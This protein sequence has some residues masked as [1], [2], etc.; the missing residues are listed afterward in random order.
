[1]DLAPGWEAR[2]DAYT[3]Q[4][5]EAW[6]GSGWCGSNQAFCQYCGGLLLPGER[7]SMEP[8][9]ARLDPEH[10]QAC[11]ASLQR[12]ITDSA[13]DHGALLKA[14]RDY[15]LPKLTAKHPLEAW[16]GDD[17][18]FPKKG[19]HSV[20]VAH[21]YCG[22]LGKQANCQVAVSVSLATGY[23]SLPVA[24]RLYL[25]EAWA[26]DPARCKA[27][28]VPK[29][30]VFQKKWEIA[31]ALADQLLREGVPKAPFL[32]DAGY[33]PVLAFRQGLTE[34]GFDYVVGVRSDEPIWPPGWAPL[35]PGTKSPVEGGRRANHL[36]QNPEMPLVTAKAWALGLPP[37]AWQDVSWRQGTQGTLCSR[38]AAARIRPA[39]GCYNRKSDAIYLI[40]QEE[41]LIAEW[42]AGEP[43]PT[44]YWLSTFPEATSITTL[45]YL[46]KLRWRIEDDYEDLK[47][48]VGLADF[49]GRTW[50][51]FHHH[52]SLCIAARTFLSAERSR[53]SPPTSGIASRLA[54]SA[55]SGHRPWRR[56]AA[57]GRAS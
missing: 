53:L 5:A 21:Q 1:M 50:Q 36:R 37:E 35:A 25:P 54:Q 34:R 43:A 40:P 12:L 24:Y 10:V 11:H 56:P 22:N 27:A 41:W 49:E 19:T 44:R 7:K 8:M 55:L 38:F 18:S 20:G 17:T 29:D 32:W 46:A 57:K 45:V 6:R 4:L 33:G 39:Q 13:W 48:E 14:V 26:L 3:D 23:G 31:L 9:A 52:A 16:I 47:Q 15:S 2:L 30:V 42:P 28:G 51:G